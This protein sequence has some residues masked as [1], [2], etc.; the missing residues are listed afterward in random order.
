LQPVLTPVKVSE[1]VAQQDV[2]Q[3][4]V[5]LA[6][7]PPETFDDADELAARAI[8]NYSDLTLVAVTVT[9]VTY[10]LPPE[11]ASAIVKF[12]RQVLEATV[13]TI[14]DAVDDAQADIAAQTARGIITDVANISAKRYVQ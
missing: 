6:L 3:E 10:G 13:L 4:A 11:V 12:V 14:I 7:R 9:L 5:D 1:F 8:V 2:A